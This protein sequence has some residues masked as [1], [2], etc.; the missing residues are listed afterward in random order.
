MKT[1]TTTEFRNYCLTKYPALITSEVYRIIFRYLC[2]ST[3]IS[4]YSPYRLMFDAATLC[5]EI[6]GRYWHN[7]FNLDK[8]KTPVL[9]WAESYVKLHPK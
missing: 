4:K 8:Y 6:E 3:A 2:F 7:N 9:E 1:W 5:L